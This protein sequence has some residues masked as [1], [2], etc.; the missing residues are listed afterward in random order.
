[1]VVARHV[2]ARRRY[3]VAKLRPRT[4]YPRSSRCRIYRRTHLEA[5]S[6]ARPFCLSTSA[7]TCISTGN[8]PDEPVF[9]HFSRN[10]PWPSCQKPAVVLVGEHC[11]QN[12]AARKHRRHMPMRC[13]AGSSTRDVSNRRFRKSSRTR[14]ESAVAPADARSTAKFTCCWW[15]SPS[16]AILS[17]CRRQSWPAAILVASGT[18]PG[19]AWSIMVRARKPKRR[20]LICRSSPARRYASTCPFL[21]RRFCISQWPRHAG[22]ETRGARW[23]ADN[24]RRGIEIHRTRRLGR[25]NLPISACHSHPARRAPIGSAMT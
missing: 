20:R 23:S 9:S 24:C 16:P 13:S 8:Q 6:R 3:R 21:A 19:A 25:P 22:A 18:W 1:M 11:H 17:Q 14:F 2:I 5:C 4:E 12:E 7:S 10:A 15:P